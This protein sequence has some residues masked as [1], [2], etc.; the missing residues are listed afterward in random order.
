ANTICYYARLHDGQNAHLSLVTLLTELSRENL[1]TMSPAGIAGAE[2][3]IFCP[4]GNMA[5]AAAVAEML[6]Q[7]HKGY[8]EFIPALPQEWNSGSFTGL[9]VRGGGVVS[10]QWHKGRLTS[11]TLT[12]TNDNNFSLLIPDNCKLTVKI[13]DVVSD[14]LTISDRL[15]QVSLRKN[16]ICEIICDKK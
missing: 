5:G 15:L 2:G 11:A 4:D 10:A 14:S 9:C 16:E 8:I 12:A 3:D 6:L 13:N 1:F 7:S